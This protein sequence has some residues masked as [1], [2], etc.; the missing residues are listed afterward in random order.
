MIKKGLLFVGC[1]QLPLLCAM[2]S[3]L[4]EITPVSFSPGIG[5]F[6]FQNGSAP[7]PLGDLK[8]FTSDEDESLKGAQLD[9]FLA[10]QVIPPNTGFSLIIAGGF[11]HSAYD[12]TAQL[13]TDNEIGFLGN[14]FPYWG[15]VIVGDGPHVLYGPL[16][17]SI[18][19]GRSVDD[20]LFFFQYRS[21]GWNVADGS[22]ADAAVAQ[23]LWEDADV[24]FDNPNALVWP[25][26]VPATSPAHYDTG[27]MPEPT[28][29]LL[30]L[31]A[32]PALRRRQS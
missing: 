9:P 7:L 4:A 21:S 32:I 16:A 26:Q 13:K 28:S 6:L 1:L 27:P 17:A 29:L 14:Q 11:G 22:L 8:L 5:W 18:G 10:S 12:G 2:A 23:G 30:A 31:I 19:L 25:T 15:D 3:A 20:L 24:Y